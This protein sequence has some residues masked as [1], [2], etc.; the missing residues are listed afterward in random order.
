[1]PT[2]DNRACG[3]AVKRSEKYTC[4]GLCRHC[5]RT[6]RTA[7]RV[8]CPVPYEPRPCERGA[9]RLR[10]VRLVGAPAGG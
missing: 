1:M 5:W 3:K 4:G 6:G 9:P 2:C 7:K 10:D 8:P